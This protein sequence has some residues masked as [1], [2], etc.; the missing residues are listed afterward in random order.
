MIIKEQHQFKKKFGQNFIRS[1]KTIEKV[2]NYL[3]I[4]P[5][6]QVMEIG[7]G[8]GRFTEELLNRDPKKLTLIEIDNELVSF[9]EKKFSEAI[10]GGKMEI[11]N[12]DIMSLDLT[13]NSLH[14][15]VY[16]SLPYN[17]SKRIIAK[18]LEADNQP[19]RMVFIVQKEVAD[20]YVALPKDASFLS[21]Y[22]RVFA[23]VELKKII[24][25][26]Q[27]HPMPKVDGGILLI[28]PHG[29]IEQERGRAISKFIFNGFRNKRKKL[30]RNLKSIYTQVEWIKVFEDLGLN[31]N[32]RA[33]ELQFETWIE[34]FSVL[35]KTNAENN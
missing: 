21:N 22:I 11:I 8:D 14:P 4:S 2:L 23:D 1:T 26:S 3:E 30:S 20:D 24:P 13:T 27:F 12:Q 5:D 25:K 34:L 7:P 10:T 19:E 32:S 28:K 18:F 17:I 35:E 9:L 31:P 33:Q 6:D 16:G 29:R 15:K